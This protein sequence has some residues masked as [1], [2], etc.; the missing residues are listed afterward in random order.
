MSEDPTQN[1][2]GSRSFEERVFNELRAINARFDAIDARLNRIETRLDDLDSRLTTL[3][4]RVERRLIE[5]RPIWEAMQ[6]Q[7]EQLNEKV[8]RIN[9]K[10]DVVA[11]DLY[12]MR[13]NYKSLSKRM[14]RLE[15]SQPR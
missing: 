15:D 8:D 5:T 10:F 6:E 14:T 2:D 7:L 11:S 13:S 12:E 4:E 9:E 3:E 1:M